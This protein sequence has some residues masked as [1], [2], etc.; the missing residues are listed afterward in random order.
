VLEPDDSAARQRL[1]LKQQAAE[2]AVTFIK[3][4]MVIGLGTGSTA[5]FAIRR[6]ADLLRAGKL[7]DIAGFATSRATWDEA[8]RLGIPL[9]EED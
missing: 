5:T 7:H 1:L 9:L 4:G 3:P 2:R 8:R 6:I